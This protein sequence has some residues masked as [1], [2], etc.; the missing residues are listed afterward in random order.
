M[1]SGQNSVP[2]VL[3]IGGHDPSGGAG[4]QADIEAVAAN[5]AHAVTLVTCLTLQDSCN[6]WELHPTSTELLTA[7]AE[8]LLADTQ[9][10]AIK[11]GLLGSSEMV[12]AVAAI[13]R[14]LPTV[15]CVL[16]PVLAAGGGNDLAGS[17]LVDSIQ[18]ELLPLCRLLTPNT[19]E[20]IRLSGLRDD[21]EPQA[22]AEKLLSAGCD[23]VLTTGTHDLQTADKV[24]HRLFQPA[25]PAFI[26]EWPRLPGEYHGSGCTLASA[27]AAGLAAG[28]SLRQ[29]V[30]QGLD[31]TWQSLN[32]AFSSGRCQ[33]T[34]E[35]LYQ[36]GPRSGGRHG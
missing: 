31:F 16:D 13:L 29:A 30:E 4:I 3:A 9:V 23:A 14:K 18:R 33:A 25:E 5:G 36:L 32:T 21:S 8:L 20:A 28:T 6:V 19:H 15:P 22:C 7:Q 2:V 1:I 12:E 17:T 10:T 34:P 24:I 35:R 26:S 27:I 11:I